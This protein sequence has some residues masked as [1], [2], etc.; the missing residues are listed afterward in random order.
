[1]V[2]GIVC[3]PPVSLPYTVI[4]VL[5]VCVILGLGTNVNV[6]P[7]SMAA[8]VVISSPNAK[9]TVPLPAAI[10]LPTTE[11]AFLLERIIVYPVCVLPLGEVVGVRE[12]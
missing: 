11:P 6:C 9:G 5:I 8:V 7:T 12:T 3:E 2:T 10:P 4:V 1:M